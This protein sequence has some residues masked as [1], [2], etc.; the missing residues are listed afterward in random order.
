MKRK[1]YGSIYIKVYT[2]IKSVGIHFKP[3][4]K[5]LA[6]KLARMILQAIEDG[7]GID[8]TSFIWKPNK[9]KK[10]QITVTSL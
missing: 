9:E 10:V 2:G 7:K 6:L 5:E 3:T 8:I 1:N 4:E